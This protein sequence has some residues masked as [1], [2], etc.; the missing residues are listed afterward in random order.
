[1]KHPKENTSNSLSP[2]NLTVLWSLALLF[3]SIL[4][5]SSYLLYDFSQYKADFYQQQTYEKAKA[6]SKI[7]KMK[8]SAKSFLSLI[9]SR[10]EAA[11]ENLER[12][13]KILSS[14]SQ[15]ASELELPA[16]MNA[17]YLT[18]SKPFVEITRFGIQSI[19]APMPPENSI[20]IKVILSNDMFKAMK[21][22]SDQEAE[23]VGF[24]TIS[25]DKSRLWKGM[26]GFKTINPEQSSTMDEK[27]VINGI[28]FY[29]RTPIGAW[30]YLEQNL[31][32]YI[33]FILFYL[34]AVISIFVLYIALHRRFEATYGTLISKLKQD[35]EQFVSSEFDNQNYR[36]AQTALKRIRSLLVKRQLAQIQHVYACLEHLVTS[37]SDPSYYLNEE[38][39]LKLVTLC[40]GSLEA[41]SKGLI[42]PLSQED[43]E[44]SEIVDI[45]NEL[46]A[47]R[48]SK[49]EITVKADY[50]DDFIIQG[51]QTFILLIL[52]NII[53]KSI[54]RVQNLGKVVIRE[55]FND[56]STSVEVTDTGPSLNP[57]TEKLIT[58]SFELFVDDKALTSI[59]DSLDI[60]IHTKRI[61]KKNV[62]TL[63]LPLPSAESS[64]DNVVRLF[65]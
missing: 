2:K 56:G 9:S 12:I 40:T 58:D 27:I 32:K 51:D 54:L 11:P 30:E 22:I 46:F 38:D 45:I 62:T 64:H 28:D 16:I 37:R 20:K 4:L 50:P 49:Y 41:M 60:S 33:I 1:M 52:V 21:A 29:S 48:L 63:N 65:Q 43:V 3:M 7:L 42:S 47:D 15:I 39:E 31:N 26:S 61:R 24:L 5:I 14:S 17:R 18:H 36:T 19:E 23:T 10:I 53:G 25:F 8:E 6:K 35:I 44:L 55:S 34:F 57:G 13:Q 59:C